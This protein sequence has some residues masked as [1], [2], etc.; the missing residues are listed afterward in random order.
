MDL[1]NKNKV[2]D[3]ESESKLGRVP[4]RNINLNMGII[5]NNVDPL[6]IKVHKKINPN[7][8]NIISIGFNFKQIL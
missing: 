4:T 1:E 7:V 8:F 2:P 3:P 6:M 5:M